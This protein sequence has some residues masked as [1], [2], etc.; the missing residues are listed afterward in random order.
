MKPAAAT[1]ILAL[2]EASRAIK[3]AHDAAIELGDPILKARTHEV[4]VDILRLIGRI[5]T[6]RTTP[7]EVV[8]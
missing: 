8:S 3:L 4:G 7:E 1:M 6:G 5:C 2:N